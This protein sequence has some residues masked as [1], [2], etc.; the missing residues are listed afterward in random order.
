MVDIPHLLVMVIVMFDAVESMTT[1]NNNNTNIPHIDHAALENASREELVWQ[2]NCQQFVERL[3][4]RFAEY[5]DITQ[6]LLLASQQVGLGLSLLSQALNLHNNSNNNTQYSPIHTI[7]TLLCFPPN[8][9]RLSQT[10]H[11]HTRRD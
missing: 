7:S 2:E 6:P 4:T 3:Q 11:C 10:I 9:A 8:H 5:N 1:S